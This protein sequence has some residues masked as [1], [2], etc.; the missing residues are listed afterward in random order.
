MDICLSNSAAKSKGDYD[1]C[2]MLKVLLK[3]P[4]VAQLNTKNGIDPHGV[5][6]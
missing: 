4:R 1:I 3:S 5:K 6:T 2:R